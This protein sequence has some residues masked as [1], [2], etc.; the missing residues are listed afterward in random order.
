MKRSSAFALVFAVA[1]A[2]HSLLIS[3]SI[4]VVPT[5]TWARVSAPLAL[6]R[7]GAVATRLADGRVLIAGGSSD[8]G[9]NVVVVGSAEVFDTDDRFIPVASM[10]VP[11]SDHAAVLLKDGR[12]LV[13]GGV[14][15][16][17]AETATAEIYDPASNTWAGAGT[18]D[19]ARSGHTASL[20]GDGRVLIAGGASLEIYDPASGSFSLAGLLSPARKHHAAATLPDGRVVIAGGVSDGGALAHVDVV[21]ADGGLTVVAE[22]ASART[23]L[24][25][26]ALL[27]GRV[28]FAGGSDGVHDLASIEVFEPATGSIVSS[29]SSLAIARS[30]HLAFLLPH[31][32]AVLVVGGTSAG[33]AVASAELYLPWQTDDVVRVTGS[34]TAARARAVGA[35]ASRNGEFL[36]A[37]GESDGARH[38][39]A[40]LYGFA[41]VKTDRDDYRPGT[42]VTITGAGWQPGETVTLLVRES[43]R[44]HEDRVLTAVADEAGNIVNEEFAPEEHDLGVRFYLTA[45]G[46]ASEAQITFTDD[47]VINTIDSIA[48]ADLESVAITAG[49]ST[50]VSFYGEASNTVPA[51]DASG[52]NSTGSSPANVTLLVP[53]GVN[54]SPT[55]FLLVGCG[56]GSA[57][58]VTFGSNTPGT[59]TIAI[60]SVTGGKAGS[61]WDTSPASFS[62]IVTSPDTTPPSAPSVDIVPA[63]VTPAN[64]TAVTITITGEVAATVSGSVTS[65]GGGTPVPLSGTIPAGGTLT[66]TTNFSG[67]DD[68]TLTASVTLTDA[69]NNTSDAGTDT[70]VKDTAV[71]DA[72]STPDLNT[73]SDSGSSQT[74]N[75]TND[76]TPTFTGTAESG[77]V[78]KIYRNGVEVGTGV[79]AGG[80]YSITTTSLADGSHSITAR[81][82]DAA[83]NESAPSGALSVTIDTAAPAPPSVPDLLAS[84]DSGSSSIDNVT[85]DNTPTFDGTAEP[86]ATVTLY[87]NGEVACT[88]VAAGG[89]YSTTT[90]AIAD[91]TY[92]FAATAGDAAGNTSA[93]SAALNVTI[94]TLAPAAPTTP[95]LAATSD[96]GSSWIDN[97]TN[98]NTPTF[99]GAAEAG[100]TVTLYAGGVAHGNGPATGGSYNVTATALG[101]GT[102]AITANA[103]DL[104]GNLSVASGALSITID[105]VAP[106]API[107]DVVPQFVN[108]ANRTAVPI[109]IAGEEGTTV[110]GAVTSGAGSVALGGTIPAGGVLNVNGDLSALSDGTVTAAAALTD[111]AGN[112]GG[113]GTD[114]AVKD[115]VAPAI[116]L[117]PP[118]NG[119]TYTLNQVVLA[120]Y[121]CT[122]TGG[123]GVASCTGT[124]ADGAPIDTAT[125]GTKTFQVDATDSAGNPASLIHSY[126]VQ[127]GVCVL[128]DQTKAHR[129][130]STVPVKLY[131]CDASGT[132]VSSPAIVVRATAL[133]RLGATASADVEDSGNANPDSNFR[134]DPSLGP[135]GGYIFNL[136][137]KGLTTGTWK[138]SFLAGSDPLAHDVLFGV[139]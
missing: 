134:Y 92:G 21:D 95:D 129:S 49:E 109:T 130:G 56:T 15:T 78:V 73:A 46:A 52:C 67:L 28:L 24:T 116:V 9:S 68:G 136:S 23:G 13:T 40:E 105:T 104:A 48:D 94:D 123:T 108:L 122:D 5:G 102:H 93:A 32:N 128:Y 120:S 89:A 70:A 96:S 101:D 74:D 45:T 25:A 59:Y 26:T 42:V 37:G 12:V 76:N 137:T 112:T 115:T 10:A 16:D 133:N 131:L 138:L 41:T 69:G 33:T 75:I 60:S 11:R 53:P 114:S 107:V 29:S 82:T 118:G 47:R 35:A 126:N 38:A 86:D 85:N 63:F 19:E 66:L 20:L 50:S 119:A 17:G 2:A 36:L 79:A 6:A 3:A 43:P 100:A 51:G 81:A 30:G 110:N 84:S 97:L 121:S 39:S 124:V 54:A 18:M 139:K 125:V 135:S 77:A 1:F 88:V 4:P 98:D 55:S 14:T 103:V 90:G 99:E 113:W 22:L 111:A 132:N 87:K 117:G 61:L 34:A 44:S 106:G 71:P 65:T 57:V 72:P 27:D 83:G 62:L 31:N 64:L 7:A 8:D 80:T 58:P 91:G 127:F